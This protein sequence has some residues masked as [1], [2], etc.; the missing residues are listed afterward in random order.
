M[1][2]KLSTFRYGIDVLS[3]DGQRVEHVEPWVDTGALFSQFP[4]SMLERLGYKPDATRRFRLADG[5]I[6][7]RPLGDAKLR[8]GGETRTVTVTFGMEG[9]DLLLG[10]TT[11][12]QFTLVADPANETLNPS[13]ALL[14]SMAP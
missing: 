7:E 4:A 2:T 13:I 3:A 12:E 5:S 10:A 11:L 1:R 14:L 6:I 8:I 9:S